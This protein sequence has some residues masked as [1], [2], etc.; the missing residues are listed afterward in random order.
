LTKS[1]TFSNFRKIRAVHFGIGP[2]NCQL[3]QSILKPAA[4][5]VSVAFAVAG[6][7]LIFTPAELPAAAANAPH[8]NAPAPGA[9]SPTAA[10]WIDPAT[11]HRVVRLSTEPGSLSLYFH[12]NAYTPQGDKLII[13]TPEGLAAVDLKTRALELIAPGVRYGPG[14]SASI[15]VGRKTRTVY[16][17]KN[18]D[19]QTVIYAADVDTKATRVVSKLGFTGEFGGVTS[20]ETLIVGKHSVP[21]P[22]QPASPPAATSPAPS[23]TTN[24]PAAGRRGGRGPGAGRM[25]EF[26]VV[27][28]KTGA[29]RT[30]LPMTDNLN[31][32]QCSPTDPSLILYC[33][34][35]AWD[36]VDR[37][38]TVHTDGTGNRLMH[39][40]TMPME[41]AGHEFFGY[42]GET[43]WYDLQTPKSGV[44]WL[45]GVNAKTGERIRY[46][47][48]RG[49]W[50][51]HYNQS[52]DG[53]LFAGDG[54]GPNGVSNRTPG[55]QP[56]NPPANGQWLYLFTPRPEK[57]DTLKV[58]NE[59]VKIGRFDVEKLVDLSRHD[60]RL[61]PNLT[62]TPDDKWIVFRS[63]IQD[64]SQV[65]AVEIAKAK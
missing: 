25:L 63:N 61:E 9:F 7:F 44:F 15:E 23:G 51:V 17:Q 16:F 19:G 18:E 53:K 31:H 64:G 36:Q 4:K 27:D 41:I 37:I 11:G 39:P 43:V 21:A 24:A 8:T 1:R 62:F 60:Y 13:Y 46:P 50:S 65:Y 33:H 3:M 59:D 55:G 42:D 30:F 12:Q 22:G 56:F 45:A 38:W 10:E 20:D 6:V 34:E 26:F 52:H 40:R 14:T 57:M 2:V 58:G 5:L 48:E 28:I 29:V 35:G 54:G 47:I 49:Q 32:D